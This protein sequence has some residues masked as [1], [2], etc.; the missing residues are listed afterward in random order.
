MSG[1]VGGDCGD[2]IGY[3]LECSPTNPLVGEVSEEALN[4]I[5]PGRTR[6]NEMKV[7]TRVPVEPAQ[8]LRMLVRRVGC[9]G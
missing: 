4:K 9:R 6:R 8:H 3:V 7:E 2:Q 5:E 1:D